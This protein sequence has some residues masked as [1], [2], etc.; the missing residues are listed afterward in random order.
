MPLQ[1]LVD[2]GEVRRRLP[3]CWAWRHIRRWKQRRRQTSVVPAVGQR[4]TNIAAA[5][6]FKYSCTVLTESEQLRAICRC[7]SFSS[8]LSR[9]TSLILRVDFLLAGKRFSLQGQGLVPGVDVQRLYLWKIFQGQS[10]QRS[11]VGQKVFGFSPEFVFGFSPEW[12]S[13]SSRNRVRLQ[14]GM[15]FGIIPESCSVCPGIRNQVID[16]S[17]AD[18]ALAFANIQKAANYYGVN[19]AETSW[20]DLGIH[21]QTRSRGAGTKN[22]VARERRVQSTRRPLN[23]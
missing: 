17:D 7:S 22:A 9:R 21:P 8:F 3:G 1:L 15:L 5:A 16:V 4:P 19:L 2:G 14:P 20:R 23:R 12:C 6:R 11:G 18:R 10:E 13:E